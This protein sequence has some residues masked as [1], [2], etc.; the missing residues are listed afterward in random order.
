[1]VTLQKLSRCTCLCLVLT[2]IIYA[3]VVHAQTATIDYPFNRSIYQ[4]T[5][6]HADV[7]VSGNAF[8]VPPGGGME[9]VF[10]PGKSSTRSVKV[11][12]APY[13][14]TISALSVGE[15]MLDAFALDGTGS[16]IGSSDHRDQVGVGDII[17]AVGDSITAGEVDDILAD[18]L[19]ADGRN[20]PKD[21]YGGFEPILNDLLTVA[22]SYPNTVPNEGLPGENTNGAKTRIESLIASYPTAKTWLIAY[23]TN[24]ANGSLSSSTFKANL[25]NII[26]QIQTAIPGASIYLPRVFYH[27]ETQSSYQRIGGYDKAM[28]D[29]AHSMDNVYQGAD[30]DTLFRSNHAQF[31]NH[32][33]GQLGTWLATP[34]THHPNGIG[35]TKMAMLWK[36]ALVDRAFLVTDGYFD[37]L[38]VLDTD[39]VLVEAIKQ[40]GVVN[41]SNLL[42]VCDMTGKGPLPAGMWAVGN[43]RVKL[44]LTNGGDFGGKQIYVTLRVDDNGSVLPEGASW[45]NVYLA[46]GDTL[47]Y[48]YRSTNSSNGRIHYLTAQVDQPGMIVPVFSTDVAAPITTMAVTP[49]IPNGAYGWYTSAPK[50]SFNSMDSFGH[51]A[52]VWYAWDNDSEQR[53]WSQLPVPQGKHTLYYHATD[54]SDNSEPV[55]SFIVKLDSSVP[56]TPSVSTNVQTVKPGQTIT[57]TWSSADPESGVD[58]YVYAIGTSPGRTN[59]RTWTNVG[60]RTSATYR[61]RGSV[62]TTYYFSVKARNRAGLVSGVGTSSGVTMTQS[63]SQSAGLGK[64]GQPSGD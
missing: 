28:A 21:G 6:G 26:T 32:A 37:T 56:A 33:N 53:Y 11:F 9:F 12:D 10:D 55:R 1:M 34:R 62:G 35:V 59:I 54:D 46:L 36:M 49:R 47:L 27:D 39:R 58:R 51:P 13:I 22:R 40:A 31:P 41:G 2:F 64:H 14:T 18:N 16:R 17:V 25:Q 38:G 23:G 44:A 60:L 43:W 15:H 30:L 29:L 42:Q 8:G 57:A 50:I 4:Q 7:E 19:S 52:K 20:G 61:P 3:A 24:D 48:T 45:K 63:G 5:D